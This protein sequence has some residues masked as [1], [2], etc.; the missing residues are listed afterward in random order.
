MN[1]FGLGEEPEVHEIE[2]NTGHLTEEDLHIADLE[3]IVQTTFG[4]LDTYLADGEYA[5]IEGIRTPDIM[6][7]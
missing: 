3:E 5:D 6:N 7:F 4:P 1:R 2:E